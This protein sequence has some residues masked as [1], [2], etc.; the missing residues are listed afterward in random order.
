VKVEDTAESLGSGD[1]PVLATPR[2]LSLS[3]QATV[4]ALEG[5]IDAQLT[6]VGTQ[7]SLSHLAALPVGAEVEV[8]AELTGVQ[9]RQLTFAVVV[10]T[11]DGEIVA[12]GQVIRALV[13][14]D[15]FLARLRPAATT[16]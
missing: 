5:V 6:T 16:D 4:A 14:R 7:V 15:R 10:G 8:R 2:V 9:G 12:R 11:T 3:E 1:V 13:D